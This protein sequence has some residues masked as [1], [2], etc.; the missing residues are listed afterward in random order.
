MLSVTFPDSRK[1]QHEEKALAIHAFI[2]F[3]CNFFS[4]T[5][6]TR[7]S[8]SNTKPVGD[9]SPPRLQL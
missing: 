1:L 5:V 3:P 6:E 7:L 8:R 2:F 4:N 9:V